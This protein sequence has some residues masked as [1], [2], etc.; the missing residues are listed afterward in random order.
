M[1]S[2]SIA[3]LVAYLFVAALSGLL[4]ALE[5]W[6]PKVAAVAQI[7]AAFGLDLPRLVDALRRL[8][9]GAPVVV[10]VPAVAP[11]APTSP[12]APDAPKPRG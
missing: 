6:S 4:P 12:P 1:P 7:L 11:P 9:T 3:L 8:V 10:A 2:T 5:A